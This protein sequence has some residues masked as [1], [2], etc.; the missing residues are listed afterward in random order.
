[1]V[2]QSTLTKSNASVELP[3]S[4]RTVVAGGTQ[5]IGA[6]IALRFALAGASVWLIGRSE[7]RGKQV[8]DQLKLASAEAARRQGI[9]EAESATNRHDFFSADLSNPKEVKRVAKTIIEKAGDEGI[10]YLVQTQ[11]GPP[12]GKLKPPADSSVPVEGGFAVQ[13]LSR[14]G[15]AYLLTEASAINKGIC[16]VASPAQGGSSPLDV[17]D[18]DFTKAHKAGKFSEGYLSIPKQGARDSSVLD[19]V[20]QTLAERNPQLSILHLFPG[21]VGTD[22]VSN[23]GFPS[24][25]VWGS[26]LAAATGL[27]SSPK[28]GGYP[29]VPFYLLTHPEAQKGLIRLG[30]AN[31]HGPSL[32]RY[33]MT[34]NVTDKAVRASIWEKLSGYF[35]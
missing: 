35:K 34:S 6:G 11:G 13:C 9:P 22:A 31:L 33:T 18:L 12:T 2:S 24:L 30:E 20:A 15:L 5:G 17:D 27:I 25:F 26:K 8:I 28:P 3:P 32:K 21:V 10:D 19:S 23:A 1:M 29:E 14:F 7:E 4:T 16:M